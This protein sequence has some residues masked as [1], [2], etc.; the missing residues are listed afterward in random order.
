MLAES[1]GA[2]D[3][4]RRVNVEV[5]QVMTDGRATASQQFCDFDLKSQ[6]LRDFTSESRSRWLTRLDFA[7]RELPLPREAHGRTALG[8]QA[9]PMSDN[10]STD[11]MNRGHGGP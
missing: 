4:G 3:D 9:L 5:D 7:A 6:L 2:G 8:D 1:H 11:D 10:G